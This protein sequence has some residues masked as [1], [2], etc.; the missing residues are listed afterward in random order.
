MNYREQLARMRS[1]YSRETTRLDL[2][3]EE[4]ASSTAAGFKKVE[5]RLSATI[6][7]IND[8]F[9][10]V[11]QAVHEQSLEH[12]ELARTLQGRA[13]L[14]EDR[15]GKM[16]DLIENSLDAEMDEIRSRL[17]ALERRPA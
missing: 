12:Q 14:T 6:V 3:I 2:R 11:V 10:G 1:E 13:R 8:Q 17:E 4:L 15:L 16:L 7:A 5:D 9:S